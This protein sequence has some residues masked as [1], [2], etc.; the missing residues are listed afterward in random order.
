MKRILFIAED[1]T[2]A[3]VVRLVVLARS[4]DPARYQIHFACRNFDNMVFRDGEFVRYTVFTISRDDVQRAL[5]RGQR[6]YEVKTLRRYVR[7]ELAIIDQVRP[8]L[9]VS[10][11]RLSMSVSAP[12][13]RVP[14]AALINAYWSPRALRKAWPV[15]DNPIISVVGEAVAARYF[16]QAIPKA[17][18]HFAKPVNEVRK[19]HGLEPIGS[20][21]EVLTYSNHTLFPDIPMLTPVS[22]QLPN[23]RFVGPVLWSPDVPLP[24]WWHQLPE[25]RPVV[26]VTLGSSGQLR[27]LPQVLRAL[28]GLPVTAVL[29]TAGRVDPGPLPDNVRAV[30]WVPGSQAARRA[31]LV[32]CNGGC[33]TAYQALSAGKPVLGI[34]ANFDQHLAIAAIEEHGAGLRLRASSVREADVRAAVT[35]LLESDGHRERAQAMGAEMA[36][37]DAPALFARSIDALLGQATGARVAAR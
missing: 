8:D 14:F 27:A 32:I 37:W 16:P 1:V 5:A 10:D 21:L 28:G 4:L 30:D 36:R 13:A 33:S 29:A 9:I 19:E 15:P 11:F 35:T 31:A 25:D 24:G 3:Q 20:M 22:E 34:A 6:P 17:F 26:Y 7:E 2:L 18:R 23:E 12:A